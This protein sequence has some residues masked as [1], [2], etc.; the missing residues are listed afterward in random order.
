MISYVIRNIEMIRNRCTYEWSHQTHTHTLLCWR[1]RRCIASSARR[2]GARSSWK[3]RRR[4]SDTLQ[5]SAN[6]LLGLLTQGNSGSSNEPD[7]KPALRRLFAVSRDLLAVAEDEQLACK[8]HHSSRQERQM[9]WGTGGRGGRCRSISCVRLTSAALWGV[10][11]RCCAGVR[12][13]GFW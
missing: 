12:E 11:A 2:K 6:C 10:S 1:S 13:S 3:V 7:W 5:V 4:R 9:E 8:V